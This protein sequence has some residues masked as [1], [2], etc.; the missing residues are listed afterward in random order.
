MKKWLLVLALAAGAWADK[1]KV[2]LL[3][4]ENTFKQLGWKARWEWQG[5]KTALEHLGLQVEVV[6]ENQ[7]G[8]ISTPVLVM[9]NAR[10]LE[11]SSLNSIRKH[12]AGG[13]KLLAS[14]QTSYRKADNT[15]WDP[16]G[17]A[18]G[19]ELGVK[20]TRWN[21][22]AGETE[23]LKLAPPYG[24][25]PLARHQAMIVEASPESY[26]LA[27]WDKP[28]EAPSIVQKGGA[29]YLGEDLLV[30]E[31]SHSKQV[32]GLLA[33]LL[34]R[35]DS[36]LRL[37]LP[38]TSPP[39]VDP[40]L[41]FSALPPQPGEPTVRVGL[42]TLV[43][44]D[45]A[46]DFSANRTI[47]SDKNKPLGKHLH[48][49]EKD[50]Q[51]VQVLPQKE[52]KLG[53]ELTLSASPYLNC[54]Q[55]NA[56]DTV[57]WTAYRGKLTLKA[58]ENGISAINQLPADAYLAGVIPSEVPFTFP[59][60]ALKAMAVVAR[61]YALSHLGRH[62]A[63]GFDVCSEVHCQVY[64][65][66]AAEHPYT[67]AAIQSTRGELLKF[68]DKPADCSFHACCGGHG[69]DAKDTW[70]GMTDKSYLAG[71]YD[72]LPAS[73]QADLTQ[74]A[75]FRGWLDGRY[76]AYCSSAGRFRWEE[77]MPWSQFESKLKESVPVMVANATLTSLKNVE[78]TRRD[79]SGRVA[80]LKLSAEPTD[81]T[82][83]GDSVRWL[84]SAGKIG[85]GGLQSS[86]FYLDISGEGEAKII[87]LR[88]GGWGHGV[89]LCQEGAAGRA[90]SGQNYRQLLMHY[91]PGT[92]L[93]SPEPIPTQVFP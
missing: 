51:L 91:Y 66:L 46:L 88:G 16:N 24:L 18:L 68:R 50:G 64:R 31:N 78:V 85:A 80:E 49:L 57:R 43:A 56:N 5:A 83:G 4:S 11:E 13:G 8:K 12:L 27:Q 17:L 1:P 54:W 19:P 58:G 15:S 90:R 25:I 14:Y 29:I 71:T 92:V 59:G 40:Q 26:V 38:K 60:E 35:L 81:L 72:Q 53:S 33:G 10:N 75:A 36:K 44:P 63:E 79:R 82:L 22:T 23:A 93:V 48:I 45:G 21:G 76:P 73:P 87:R 47:L 2:S 84:T 39:L 77:T 89:G 86:L 65:G 70:P 55:E 32:L 74:E 52:I 41:A 69:V 67:T 6:N 28:A 20:F 30:P 9:C 37:S 7:L 34:N 61:T 3:R 42:G 62:N